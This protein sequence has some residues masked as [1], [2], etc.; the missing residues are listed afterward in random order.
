MKKNL[1]HLTFFV[2]FLLT[3]GVCQAQNYRVEGVRVEGNNRVDTAAFLDQLEHKGPTVS[4][5]NI[6][7]DVKTLYTTGFFDQVSAKILTEG[8]KSYLK[9]EVTEKPLIRKVFIKGNENVSEDK[10][11]EIFNLGQNRFLDRARVD[12]MI[13][14]AKGYYQIRGYYDSE[15]EYSV[16]PVGE[17]QVDMTMTVDEGDKY[18]IGEISVKGLKEVDEDDLI[19]AMQTREYTWWS[20]WL[21]GSG[22]LNLDMLENDRNLMRQYFLDNGYLEATVSSP[23]IEKED[24]R[25]NIIFEAEEGPLYEVGNI[26]ASGDLIDGQ[27]DRTI[28]GISSEQGEIFRASGVREDT[29]QISDKFS[30]RGYAFAN[31]VPNTDIERSNRIVNLDF[32]VE[33]GQEVYINKI[34]IKGNDSTYDHVIRREI[35]ISERDKYDGAKIKRSETLLRRL[36]YF[37]E[38]SIT[39]EPTDSPNEV[40]LVVSVREA[41]TGT[42][43]AGAGFSSSDGVLF[44]GRVSENNIAGT[45]RGVALNADLGD[46][47]QNFILTLTDRRFMDSYYSLEANALLTEREFTDFNREIRGGG[48]EVA[49]PLEEVFGEWAEDVQFG[50]KYEYLDIEISRVEANAA[51]LIKN[52]EGKT[53]ASGLTPQLTRSTIDNPLNPTSGS[54]QRLSFE[55]TGLG[56]TEEYWLA[57]FRNRWYQ[58]L[59]DTEAGKWVFSWNFRAS[60]GETYDGSPFP[61]FRRFFPGGINS[62]RGFEN[63]TL[64]PK[65][66][67]GSEFGG[68]KQLVNN[69]E[70]LFPLYSSAG[71]RGVFFYD[72]GEAFDDD[73]NID[74]GS[75]RQAYGYGI[76]W[77][78][79][80]GPIRVEIGYPIDRETGEDSVVTLFSFGA[81]L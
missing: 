46:E 43:S 21:T 42:F 45:G 55:A 56:G 67:Q 54:N 78:S 58:P 39:T 8:G 4:S 68:S 69:F 63:R 1:I 48:L 17:N 57:D 27:V 79:P 14:S 66:E 5:D 15:F 36:G 18:K 29:F 2:L 75:L 19:D 33:K 25:L 52:N 51:E 31:V 53:S 60:Y 9:Y 72:A 20:S 40:N 65:D 59:F 3:G 44:N 81:P 77:M 6:S 10:L 26:S 38:V 24:G 35:R 76:R 13:R 12:S 80:L 71:L 73:V 28:E 34:I 37:E 47:R 64:G 7:E 41:A 23:A 32:A 11:G 50:V 30:E 62:V 61:L 70:I 74:F 49:Y 22:R 16:V